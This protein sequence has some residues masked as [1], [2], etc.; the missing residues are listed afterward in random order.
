MKKVKVQILGLWCP[1]CKRLF[2]S[3]EDIVSKINYD[4]VLEHFDDMMKIVEIW[5]MWAPVFVV[6]DNVITAWKV[7]SEEEIRDAIMDRVNH[8]NSIK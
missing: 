3:V 7:P 1:T 8:N 4:I 5:A 2:K 6:D